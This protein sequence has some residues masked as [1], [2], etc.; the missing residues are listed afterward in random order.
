MLKL[1]KWAYGL[2][3]RQERVRIAAHLSKMASDSAV[4]QQ[5]LYDDLRRDPQPRKKQ[6]DKLKFKLEVE[7]RIGHIIQEIITPKL[8]RMDSIM[9]P[10]DGHQGPIE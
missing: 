4:H 7:D 10:E 2:G 3:V 6:A 1:L 9:F 5:Q 8:S